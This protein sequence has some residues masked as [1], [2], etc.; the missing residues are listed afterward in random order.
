MPWEI[1]WTVYIEEDFLEHKL[2]DEQILKVKE[3]VEF[4]A[5]NP[6]RLE[7]VQGLPK[8]YD[9][10]KVRYWKFRIFLLLDFITPKIDCLR[11]FPDHKGYEKKQ[12]NQILTAAIKT[13]ES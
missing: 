8:D 12:K 10:R 6:R 4:A 7:K 11:M 5:Q 1:N 3:K 13:S 2:S 9:I